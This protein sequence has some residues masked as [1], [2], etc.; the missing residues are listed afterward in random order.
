MRPFLLLALLV[1]ATT[2]A[3]S[4]ELHKCCPVGQMLQDNTS[5]KVDLES[6][7]WTPLIY[8]VAPGGGGFQANPSINLSVTPEWRPVCQDGSLPVMLK[9]GTVLPLFML[10]EMNEQL[11]LTLPHS[12][13]LPIF[14]PQTFCVDRLSALVCGAPRMEGIRNC[15][16]KDAAYSESLSS[17][18]HNE[19]QGEPLDAVTNATGFPHCSSKSSNYILAGELEGNLTEHLNGTSLQ[20]EPPPAAP[21]LIEDYCLV[22]V[23]ERPERVAVLVCNDHLLPDMRPVD[24]V[25]EGDIRLTLYPA[26]LAISAF[27]LAATLAT[28]FLVP[29]AHHALHWRCQTCHVACLLVADLLLAFVQFSGRSITERSPETCTIMA[30]LMHFFFLSAFFWL[31][32]MCFNIWWTFR[33]LR[34]VSADPAQER[35]RYRAFSVYAWGMPLFITCAALMLDLLPFDEEMA[36][37]LVRPRFGEKRCWFFGGLD[38]VT[39]F[40]GP[41]GLLLIL[42]CMLFAA[43]TRELTCGLWRR[44]GVKTGG[45]SHGSAERYYTT[46]EIQ[47]PPYAGFYRFSKD[48]SLPLKWFEQVVQLVYTRRALFEKPFSKE[49]GAQNVLPTFVSSRIYASCSLLFVAARQSSVTLFCFSTAYSNSHSL[50]SHSRRPLQTYFLC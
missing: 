46:S 36:K 2:A 5:C 21:L 7:D 31:N 14:T 20:L 28:G 22:R 47:C 48:K 25:Q 34:P 4:R 35:F 15:C 39:F 42:N 33:D 43:T 26:G 17:C 49:C 16:G 11:I 13:D 44:E 29:K 8:A 24:D 6:E 10:L 37:S 12:A 9:S 18:K 41:V 32:A 50:H 38:I 3:A 45:G 27:F 40:Y 19:Q 30:V 23:L 1:A